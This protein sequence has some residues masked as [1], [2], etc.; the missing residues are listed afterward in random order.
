[1]NR[2]ISLMKNKLADNVGFEPTVDFSTLSFQDSGLNR[3]PSLL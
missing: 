2:S 1:L 3:S